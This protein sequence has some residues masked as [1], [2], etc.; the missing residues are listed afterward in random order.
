MIQKSKRKSIE[1]L[2]VEIEEI[3][4]RISV[5]ETHGRHAFAKRFKLILKKKKNILNGWI[6]NS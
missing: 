5:A 4:S 2:K 6:S 3:N 1:R